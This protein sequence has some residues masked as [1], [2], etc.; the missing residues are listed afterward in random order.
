[1]KKIYVHAP[2]DVR[3]DDVPSD[4]RPLGPYELRVHTELTA[5]SPGTET[6]IYSGLESDRFSYRVRYPYA[7]GY[8]NVG[9][10]V[11]V[12]GMVREY[13]VGDRVF[14]R[15]QHQ[16]ELI[17]AEKNVAGIASG[18][19]N[20]PIGYDVIARVP[21]NVKSEYALFTHLFTLGFNSLYRAD[22]R[23]G[24]NVVVIGLG[25]VGLGAVS[26]AHLAGARV[27][28]IGNDLSRLEIAKKMGADDGSLSG[29]NAIDRAQA[30]CGEPGADAIIVCAD[31]WA[32]L[33]TAIDISRRSTRI[34]VLSFPGV[35]EGAPKF[36][37][38][39]PADFYNKSISYV[40]VS[41]MPS[42]DYPPEYQRFT[43]K[44]IYRYILDRMSQGQ[45]DMTPV[46]THRFPIANIKDAFDLSL[47]KNKSAIGIVCDWKNH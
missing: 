10:V 33:K 24:E 25:V 35:G 3:L 13:K 19:P 9:R 18:D 40:A 21:D 41:W 43:V 26:M 4:N 32:A 6:R 7:L 47:S 34:A 30:F 22:Y 38:F 45:V 37:P 5:L 28:A 12:G 20:V 44:R 23:F 8:N 36:D 14:S 31:A 42:D 46:V 11:E 15:S 27:F 17:V 2:F 29:E 16:S 39:A 1:M